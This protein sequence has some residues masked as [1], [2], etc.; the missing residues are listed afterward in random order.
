MRRE[1]LKYIP[2]LDEYIPFTDFTNGDWDV[3]INS[4]DD[5]ESNIYNQTRLLESSSDGGVVKNLNI[6]DVFT[7]FLS[8]RVNC[9]EPSTQI[10]FSEWVPYLERLLRM[11]T[12]K[13]I[14]FEIGET[15]SRMTI[16]VPLYQDVMT[17]YK[18]S[19]KSKDR[20]LNIIESLNSFCWI[21]T[22]NGSEVKVA[23]KRMLYE[24]LPIEVY[25]EINAH[26]NWVNE[27]I[28]LLDFTFEVGGNQSKINIFNIPYVIRMIF[29][30]SYENYYQKYM[31]LSKKRN[32]GWDFYQSITPMNADQI[33]DSIIKEE[34]EARG[35]G[36]TVEMDELIG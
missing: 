17:V 31:F 16:D 25:E 13:E 35:D 18:D 1:S 5:I 2:S 27:T 10:D 4:Q 9:L 3:M 14:L 24:N 33:L 6:L 23:Q 30:Y 22:F 20:D 7:I 28:D 12:S 19:F 34:K 21:K 26:I 36:N 32:I 15:P 11:K 8:W 29:S